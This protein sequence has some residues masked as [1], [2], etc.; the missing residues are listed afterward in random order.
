MYRY[1]G[2][3]TGQTAGTAAGGLQDNP[4]REGNP[5]KLQQASC[6]DWIIASRSNTSSK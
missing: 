3:S 5:R 6:F 4:G 2:L 1:E